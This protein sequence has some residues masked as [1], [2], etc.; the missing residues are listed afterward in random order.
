M[1]QR[2]AVRTGSRRGASMAGV[3][4]E[5]RAGAGESLRPISGSQSANRATCSKIPRRRACLRPAPEP[6]NG[7]PARRTKFRR[8]FVGDRGLGLVGGERLA[9]F[10]GPGWP[11]GPPSRRSKFR[12]FLVGDRGLGVLVVNGWWASGGRDG[13]T[14]RRPH[15][16]APGGFYALIREE[17]GCVR[18]E[19]VPW[20]RLFVPSGRPA[21]ARAP[22][23]PTSPSRRRRG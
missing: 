23:R 9:G 5:A 4:S 21:F 17:C 14:A 3:G 12:R 16:L 8:S 11:N 18:G 15:R 1:A 19:A 2:P 22:S 7:P 20:S 10:R 6:R 13:P